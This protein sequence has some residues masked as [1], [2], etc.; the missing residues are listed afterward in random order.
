MLKRVGKRVVFPLMLALVV[1]AAFAAGS[2]FKGS[3]TALGAAEPAM[4]DRS[5]H[6]GIPSLRKL[7]ERLKPSVV[8]IRVIQKVA[9]SSFIPGDA[10]S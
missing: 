3:G 7:V 8:N 4:A 6:A 10:H 1:S 9:R 5:E 2:Y